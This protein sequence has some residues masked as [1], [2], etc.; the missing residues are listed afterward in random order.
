MEMIQ[1]EIKNY[2]KPFAEKTEWEG[3]S[4]VRIGAGGYEA[5]IIPGIGGN[6]I[7]LKNSEKGLDILRTPSDIETFRARP[8]VYGIPVLFP[9]NRI[10]DGTFKASG[11]VYNFP[12]NEPNNN[13]NHIHGFLRTRPWEVT[14]IE[15]MEDN[16]VVELT[17]RADKN[18]D[19]YTYY[20]HEFEF[21]LLYSISGKGLDQKATIINNSDSEMPMG[22]G[23]HTAFKVPFCSN[24]TG[25][26]C[27]IMVSVGEKWE[28]GP[29]MLPT[30]KIFP[31]SGRDEKLRMDGVDTQGSPA[32]GHFAAK[33]LQVSGR[34]FHGAIIED[35][36]NGLR[37]IY[38]VGS[39][40]KHWMIWNET[41]DK[42]F[43]CPEPQT[44][45]VNAPNIK[46]PDEV[47]GFIMLKSGQIWEDKCS[48][49]VE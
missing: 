44:W 37:L 2:K 22:L 31:L 12:V 24:S 15:S 48:I 30:G 34:S 40:Y 43:I 33:P 14:K 32:D 28:L 8:Q 26:D 45:A 29:R 18:T 5:L 38:E 4:A 19:F 49:Y 41:G 39:G 27:K 23:F 42:G 3:E 35:K 6:L 7:Q 11:R 13:H 25:K 21:K 16:A 36:S 17:F 1:V 9:P 46:L 20:P 10:E 47:T